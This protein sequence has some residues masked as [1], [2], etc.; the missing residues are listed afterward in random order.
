MLLVF[1]LL[2]SRVYFSIRPVRC[3]SGVSYPGNPVFFLSKIYKSSVG[4]A[5]G[6][7]KTFSF[8][9]SAL[10]LKQYLFILFVRKYLCCTNSSA[11]T[12]LHIQTNKPNIHQHAVQD[13]SRRL[14]RCR[15]GRSLTNPPPPKDCPSIHPVRAPD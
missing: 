3:T 6:Y 15:H 4:D 9:C 2:H 5:E 12:R 1:L 10:I 14:F 13:S 11:C 8:T 7:P